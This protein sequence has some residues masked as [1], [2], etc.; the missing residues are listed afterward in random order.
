MAKM[1]FDK[2]VKYKGT[3]YPPNTPFD[4]ED[5]DLSN[6]QKT[7]GWLVGGEEPKEALQGADSNTDSTDDEDSEE[8]NELEQL[9]KKAESLGV[10]VKK[11]WGVKKLTEVISDLTD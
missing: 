6:L 2:T 5:E 1:Y 8:D 3:S 4:V 10:V 9:R 7:G 11:S